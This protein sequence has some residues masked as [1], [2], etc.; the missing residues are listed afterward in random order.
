MELI[1][2]SGGVERRR[3]VSGLKA[4]CG[5]KESPGRKVLKDRRSPRERER[6]GSGQ[7]PNA[8]PPASPRRPSVKHLRVTSASKSSRVS[9]V[10]APPRQSSR[11][12]AR[13]GDRGGDERDVSGRRR[14]EAIERV[15]DAAE[16]VARREVPLQRVLDRHRV[17]EVRAR[18]LSRGSSSRS[19][20]R[21]RTRA[22][23]VG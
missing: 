21:S 3:G 14:A 5:R 4:R 13:G 22:R 9:R 12:V 10:L 23:G 17:R 1:G 11:E 7:T 20:S 6:M 18:G 2:V 16:R 15:V 19:R 8:H